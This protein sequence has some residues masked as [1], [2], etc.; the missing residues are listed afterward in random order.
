M[1]QWPYL[2]NRNRLTENIEKLKVTKGEKGEG[3]NEEFGTN[4]H[5][6]L[7][8][9]QINKYLLYSKGSYCKN[10]R[11]YKKEYICLYMYN[12]ITCIIVHLKLTQ[13]CKLT[14]FF[15]KFFK[16]Q[17]N[18]VV[19]WKDNK[20]ENLKK[21]LIYGSHSVNEHHYTVKT[22]SLMHRPCRELFTH[23]VFQGTS[24]IWKAE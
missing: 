7:Y 9:K 12:W 23:P 19:R 22:V 1:I 18:N 13:Y 5:T 8:I 21:A 16:Y 4:R 3:L 24:T 2:Q 17:L 10:I 20:G 14:I 15:L 11:E 6:L